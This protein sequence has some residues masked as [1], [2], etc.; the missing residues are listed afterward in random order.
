MKT[1]DRRNVPRFFYKWKLV[2]VPSGLR[3]PLSDY[4]SQTVL[5]YRAIAGPIVLP[6]LLRLNRYQVMN[7]KEPE[8]A[9]VYRKGVVN[10]QR[11]NR[12]KKL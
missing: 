5:K 9:D 3:F 10:E 7:A 6:F 8:S 12:T 2:N 4:W 11:T 1:G